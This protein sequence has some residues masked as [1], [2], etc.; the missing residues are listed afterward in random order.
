MFT[1]A[2]VKK[3]QIFMAE[4][5]ISP[6]I[7]DIADRI[8]GATNL[9]EIL[10]DLKDDLTKLFQAERMTIYTVDG[11]NKELVSQFM[12]AGE[13]DEIRVPVSNQSIV[14]FS[15]MKKKLISI[16]DVYDEMELN[17]IDARL[18]FDSSWDKKMAFRT[19]QVLATPIIFK[20]FVLGAVQ[21]I[22]HTNVIP[23]SV[24]DKEKVEG[25]VKILGN[26]F[27]IHKSMA[28]KGKTD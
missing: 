20:N 17:A 2:P 9:N 25:L 13:V 26:A 11:I 10:I 5:K 24:D 6:Q 27:H 23:F 22:N 14:G 8:F 19:R 16:S 3:K 21:F 28:A 1:K 12:S 4:K 7:S 18:H 15:V